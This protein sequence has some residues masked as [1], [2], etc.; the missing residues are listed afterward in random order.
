MTNKRTSPFAFLLFFLACNT[1]PVGFDQINTPPETRTLELLP[2][3]TDSYSKFVPLGYADYLLLGKDDE[4]EA[5][6]LI[7]FSI[8]D[9]CLDSVSSVRLILHPIDSSPLNFICRPCSTDWSTSAVTWRMADSTTQWLTPGGDY[10]HLDLGQGKMEKESTVVEFNKDYLETLVRRSYGIIIFSLDTGFTTVTNL[11][12]AK[13]G[14]RL[15]LTFADSKQRTY[16]PIE[17]AH[18]VDSSGIRAN[19]YDLLVGSSF[20]FRTYL[21][22]NLDSIPREATIARADLIFQ[23]QTLYRR[24]DTIWL[25]IHQLTE[26]YATKGRYASFQEKAAAKV[27]YVPA[28][29]DTIVSLEISRLIQNWVSQPDSNPNY[30]IFITAEPEWLK[31][32]RIKLFRSGPLSPHLRIQYILPPEDRF[33]R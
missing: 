19:P 1:L 2:E 15:V 14:P 31:P 17:D 6:I 30:G 3:S 11:T 24:Q 5:R 9:S 27:A 21:R 20:A 18:I 7:K 22:F 8:K 16:Y 23:P 10:W 26:A 28:D 29:N 13:T 25:G 33:T 4:Y 12:S 32:F